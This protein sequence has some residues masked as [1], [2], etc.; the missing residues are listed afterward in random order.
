MAKNNNLTVRSLLGRHVPDQYIIDRL[1][2][3]TSASAGKLLQWLINYFLGSNK[4]AYL[5]TTLLPSKAFKKS[6]LEK[7]LIRS[8][9][10]GCLQSASVPRSFFC[11][12]NTSLLLT[13]N[14]FFLLENMTA[15][16][17][18]TNSE[19]RE[20]EELDIIIKS[21]YNDQLTLCPVMAIAVLSS[22]TFVF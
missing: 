1:R 3:D 12:L 14:I 11:P 21:E 2:H 9:A 17:E 22:T 20:N 5:L 6:E 8:L 15:A 19:T 18:I 4:T 7:S 10:V 13:A 16:S